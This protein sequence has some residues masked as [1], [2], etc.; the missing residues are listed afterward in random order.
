M[1]RAK[2]NCL[3]ELADKI[4]LHLKLDVPGAG[5][6]LTEEDQRIIIEALR[7]SA[8]FDDQQSTRKT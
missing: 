7:F 1:C 4:E 2:P 3:T 5:Y 6:I 8:S